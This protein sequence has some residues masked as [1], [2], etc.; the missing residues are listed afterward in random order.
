LGGGIFVSTTA[1]GQTQDVPQLPVD[2][3]WQG[4]DT[5]SG[6]ES[7]LAEIRGMLGNKA[8]ADRATRAI[9]AVVAQQV[10][11]G[12]WSVQVTT[13][14]GDSGGE[15]TLQAES[16]DEAR[17][18]VA[19]LVA[20]MIDPDAHVKTGNAADSH[21]GCRFCGLARART[22]AV[23]CAEAAHT[24]GICCRV[25]FN[26]TSPWLRRFESRRRQWLTADARCRGRAQLR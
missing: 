15:R 17:R 22:Y 6:A 13:T 23:A 7:T 3:T 9:I 8:L 19:L 18:A 21:T 2:L 11:G 10:D 12:K 4:P 25:H 5:C 1:W 20:L 14:S 24:H 26:T 16:C